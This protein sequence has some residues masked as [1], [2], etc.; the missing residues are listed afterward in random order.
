MLLSI[1]YM[2]VS[3]VFYQDQFL[4]LSWYVYV[5]SAHRTRSPST[6]RQQKYC[7]VITQLP[8]HIW[9]KLKQCVP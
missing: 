7:E 2:Y 3:G 9:A 1:S 5:L 6:I 8:D 4:D